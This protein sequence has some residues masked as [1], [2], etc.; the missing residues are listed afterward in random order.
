MA[1]KIQYGLVGCGRIAPNHIAAALACPQIE[2]VALCDRDIPKALGLAEKNGLSVPVYSSAQ[3]MLAAHPLTLVAVAVDSGAHLEVA[4]TAVQAGAS[5]LVEKPLGLSLQGIDQLLSLAAEKGVQVGVC[6]QNR[7]NKAAR[8][9]KGILAGGEMGSLY[10]VTANIRWN[11]GEEYYRQAPWRGTWAGD[12]G[13]LMN[14]CIHNIDLLL[15]AADESPDQVFAYTDRLAHPNIEAEDY[16]VALLRF[17]Q[18]CYGVIE[19]TTDVYDRNFE[20]TL[21]VLGEKG[22]VRLGGKSVNRVEYCHLAGRDGEEAALQAEH[23]EDPPNVYGYGHTPL[24]Q[25]MVE[26][27]TEKRTPLIDGEAGRRAVEIILAIY[28][29]AAENRPISLPLKDGATTNYFGRFGPL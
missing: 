15:W 20:E 19:G 16:G 3:E 18:G 29:S 17:P 13:A 24:Y 4:Q 23:S 5:I 21:L 2:I 27:I 28:Q 6:H 9:L 8:F 25:D 10:S 22:T 1:S 11:R 7:F 26:A 12:G 14:Q